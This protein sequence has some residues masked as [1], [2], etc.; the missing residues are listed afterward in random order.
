M[1][2]IVAFLCLFLTSA[3]GS[4]E[5]NARKGYDT[6]TP[7]ELKEHVYYLASDR[8]EGRETAERGGRLAAEY[9]AKVFSEAGL[10][11][12]GDSGTFFQR[13]DLQ[14]SLF[15]SSSAILAGVNESKG[16]MRLGDDF[17]TFAYYDTTVTAPLFFTGYSG[18]GPLRT[19]S[20]KVSFIALSLG[21]RIDNPLTLLNTRQ[22]WGTLFGLRGVEGAA[23]TIYALHDSIFSRVA[24]KESPYRNLI[25]RGRLSFPDLSRRKAPLVL[26]TSE[27]LA[28]SLL[29]GGSTTVATLRNQTEKQKSGAKEIPQ[30]NSVTL[31]LG[32]RKEIRRVENVVGMVRGSDP[33]LC[34]E[35]VVFSAHYD[36]VGKGEDG[37]IY[38]GADDNASGTAGLMEI[39]EAFAQNSEKPKRSLLFIAMTGEE[40]GLLG[41][42]YYI[43][44]PIVPLKKTTANLN[45]DMIGRVDS[46][47][48]AKD[49]PNY[50]YV[51]GS[52]KI[53]PD[54]DSLL[55]AAND[56]SERLELDY[57]FN[58]DN[59]PNQFYRRSDH[60]NFAK[61]GIPV[62]FFFNGVHE[63]YHKPTDTADKIDYEKM[64]KIARVAYYTGWKI[65]SLNRP[66]R[67]RAN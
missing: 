3:G 35:A 64:A 20:S 13:F 23:A 31:Q 11:P 22:G 49:N 2:L 37:S 40:K 53:S 50:V 24:A 14:R 58:A 47:Y 55:R 48:R 42:E 18:N 46:S 60:Y 17:V 33:E 36:H 4:I 29:L 9:I 30:G 41:S 45:T 32:V 44:H 59:D 43:T 51:I 10:S 38:H 61:N 27:R 28:D 5:K 56:E 7:T 8:L 52:D 12:A 39:A 21:P 63:D 6:I 26:F 15:D 16:R 65:A 62:I 57:K 54:A 67:T 19:D 1:R 66:L 25:R 34:E